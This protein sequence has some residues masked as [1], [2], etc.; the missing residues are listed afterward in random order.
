M[1][2]SF[3]AVAFI[4]LVCAILFWLFRIVWLIWKR[5]TRLLHKA[6]D[7]RFSKKPVDDNT[8]HSYEISERDF[9]RIAYKVGYRH[10]KTEEILVD[11]S[12]VEIH[13]LSQSGYSQYDAVVSFELSGPNFGEFNIRTTNPDS[14]VPKHIA[15]KIQSEMRKQVGL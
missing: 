6:F 13:F 12:S 14:T 2:K 4:C 1:D 11:G 10:P 3:W 7:K 8:K 5:S 15:E 9:T